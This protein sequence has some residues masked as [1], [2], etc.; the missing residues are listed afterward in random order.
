MSTSNIKSPVAI[1]QGFTSDWIENSNE[2]E[3][4]GV[5]NWELAKLNLSIAS[6]GLSNT[7]IDVGYYKWIQRAFITKRRRKGKLV[8]KQSRKFGIKKKVR[9]YKYKVIR[10]NRRQRKFKWLYN[11]LKGKEKRLKRFQKRVPFLKKNYE[12]SKNYK[13]PLSVRTRITQ[14]LWNIG[15]K[16]DITYRNIWNLMGGKDEVD[17]FEFYR[18]NPQLNFVVRSVHFLSDS[19]I[20]SNFVSLGVWS[21]D[22]LG[23]L[24]VKMITRSSKKG[25]LVRALKTVAKVPVLLEKDLIIKRGRELDDDTRDWLWIIKIT[26]KLNPTGRTKVYWIRPTRFP[27]HTQNIDYQHFMSHVNTK[28]GTYSVKVWKVTQ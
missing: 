7:T 24:I 18:K 12:K 11:R 22:L 27:L 8:I 3:I 13:I 16:E 4:K 14:K 26:G 21:I 17:L 19:V 6:Y 10:R 28:A 25:A 1:R 9:P 20:I 2:E 23:Q 5:L 15:V